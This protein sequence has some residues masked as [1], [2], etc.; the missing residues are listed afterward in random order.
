[1]AR[2]MA[3]CMAPR[4]A[5]GGARNWQG[6][7][8]TRRAVGRLAEQVPRLPRTE[9]ATRGAGEHRS[10]GLAPLFRGGACEQGR[11]AWW[12]GRVLGPGAARAGGRRGGDHRNRR[13]WRRTD[14][15][16]AGPRVEPVPHGPR[17]FT[18]FGVPSRGRGGGK[19]RWPRC[20]FRPPPQEKRNAV[21]LHCRE[22]LDF[23]ARRAGRCAD[24]LNI[25]GEM[26]MFGLRLTIPGGGGKPKL[27][28]S[29]I[30]RARNT[31]L[32]E[33]SWWTSRTAC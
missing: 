17:Q 28:I 10:G 12:K 18:R 31:W 13:P 1:M 15:R 16:R 6:S 26:N 11:S 30:I 23:N 21:M 9:S 2:R 29:R 22:A 5:R 20:M 25:F 3:S 7:G 33:P 8:L 24:L 19:I 14:P 32:K 27:E 4:L